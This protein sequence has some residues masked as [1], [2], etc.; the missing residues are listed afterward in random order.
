MTSIPVI[1]SHTAAKNEDPAATV[2]IASLRF[3]PP[4][5]RSGNSQFVWPF[6]VEGFR[7]S[8]TATL[9]IHKYLGGSNVD[10]QVIHSDEAHIE[11]SGTFPGLTS[12][13]FMEQLL[14]VITADGSKDLLLPGIFTRIQRVFTESYDFSH[15][16]EDRTHSITYTISFVRTTIGSTVSSTQKTVALQTENTSGPSNP[17]NVSAATL[18][19]SDRVYTV[20][21]GAQ[22][23]REISA[24][25]YG[26]QD[27]W[28]DLVDLNK[29][30]ISQYNPEGTFLAFQLPTVR[31]EIGTRIV[32]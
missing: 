27:S 16:P 12:Q 32:F 2:A 14:A 8:G 5:I 17:R 10:V 21:P 23:L 18:A 13:A 30:I 6:G 24:I 19:Q 28:T 22:T 4:S 29:D 26:D 3:S 31:L 25:V 20:V 11:M 1:K 15:D 9:G 7:R